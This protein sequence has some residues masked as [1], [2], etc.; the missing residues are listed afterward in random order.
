ML[1]RGTLVSFDST[2]YTAVIRLDGSATQTLTGVRVSRAIASA[3]MVAG[4]R[5]LLAAGDH[6]D[7]AD[8]VVIAVWV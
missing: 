3:E 6:G 5:A 8:L 2:A 1:L 7:A 4:R